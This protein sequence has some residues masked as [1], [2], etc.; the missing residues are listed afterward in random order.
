[1]YIC[2]EM[3]WAVDCASTYGAHRFEGVPVLTVG[4]SRTVHL[5]KPILM[6]GTFMFFQGDLLWSMTLPVSQDIAPKL[7]YSAAQMRHETVW[8]H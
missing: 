8:E 4:A 7:P 5:R 6:G 3:G 1:M 2:C